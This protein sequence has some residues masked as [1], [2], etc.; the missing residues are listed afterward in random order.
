MLYN[1]NP[2]L[3]YETFHMKRATNSLAIFIRHCLIQLGSLKSESQAN[4]IN[5]LV[6]TRF[7]I[8]VDFDDS[9]FQFLN[10]RILIYVNR[11]SHVFYLNT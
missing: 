7:I 1:L 10:Q 6:L 3:A 5:I 9:R 8:I 11:E 2:F 4:Q